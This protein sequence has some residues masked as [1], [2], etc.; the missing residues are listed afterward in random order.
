MANVNNTTPLSDWTL[1]DQLELGTQINRRDS[2]KQCHPM[3]NLKTMSFVYKKDC[4]S[5]ANM[6]SLRVSNRGQDSVC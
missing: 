3:C 2:R 5:T 1:Y 4:P 6:K